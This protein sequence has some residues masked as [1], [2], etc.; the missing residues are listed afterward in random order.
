MRLIRQLYRATATLL[1][2]GYS[3]LALAWDRAGVGAPEEAALVRTHV[4]RFWRRFLRLMRVQ[5]VVFSESDE[6]PEGAGLFVSNHQSMLDVAILGSQVGGPILSRADLEHWP[7]LGAAARAGGTLFVDRGDRRSGARAIR[8]MRQVLKNGIPLAVF[9][10]G[11]TFRGDEVQPFKG[12]AFVA[13]RGLGVPVV[14]VGFAYEPGSEYVEMSFG[15]H[16]LNLM[17]SSQTRVVMAIGAPIFTSQRSDA[18]AQ[19][20]HAEVRGLVSRA[21]AHG[22]SLGM[23][24][25]GVDTTPAS[26][27][28]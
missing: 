24:R 4:Q 13:V 14:P 15:Q 17:G 7:V 3:L 1:L 10:E 2:T 5:V 8:E 16:A 25:F 26:P 18:L 23:R 28:E 20:A 27:I 22:D 21:R 6:I 9:P 19:K 11:A 12:G